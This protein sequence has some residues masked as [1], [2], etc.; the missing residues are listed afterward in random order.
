MRTG[1]AV[2]VQLDCFSKTVKGEGV[3]SLWKGFWP[4]YTRIG[5]RVVII[6]VVLEQMRELELVNF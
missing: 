1:L 3:A 4:A 5:P 6:F 2:N